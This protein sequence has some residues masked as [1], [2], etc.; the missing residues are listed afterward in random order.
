MLEE[1]DEDTL[2]RTR[3]RKGYFDMMKRARGHD[4]DRLYRSRLKEEPPEP[5]KKRP[6]RDWLRK[7]MEKYLK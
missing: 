3:K 4:G 7:L 6:V 5:E 1:L 2:K